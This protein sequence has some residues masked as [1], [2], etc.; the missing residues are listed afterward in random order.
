M[1]QVPDIWKK[2]FRLR[3]LKWIQCVRTWVEKR[4]DI[5]DV[6]LGYHQEEYV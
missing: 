3:T 4:K 2:L 6:G 5:D 1:K